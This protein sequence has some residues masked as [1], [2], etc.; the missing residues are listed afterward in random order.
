MNVSGRSQK[1]NSYFG[2]HRAFGKTTINGLGGGDTEDMCTQVI[3]G[4]IA[5]HLGVQR[6]RNS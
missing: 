4:L 2:F 3:P 5:E 1:A 6:T